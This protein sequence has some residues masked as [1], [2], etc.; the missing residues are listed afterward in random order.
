[1]EVIPRFLLR[2]CCEEPT[3]CSNTR[4]LDSAGVAAGKRILHDLV[5][6]NGRMAEYLSAS[7]VRYISTR[8]LL[9]GCDNSTMGELTDALC[10]CWSKGPV[11]G[12]KIAYHRIAMGLMDILSRKVPEGDLRNSLI[13]K[14]RGRE[15][16][17]R[18]GVEPS[19]PL[20]AAGALMTPPTDP[21]PAT[22]PAAPAAPRA[23]RAATVGITSRVV[24]TEPVRLTI[25]SG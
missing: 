14:K 13:P 18:P 21:T 8:D 12:D 2:L 11:H 1:M 10:S 23:A 24:P 6:L 15:A 5:D 4:Q 25:S 16:R 20:A 3:H 7:N 22:P 17:L 9:A 19:L